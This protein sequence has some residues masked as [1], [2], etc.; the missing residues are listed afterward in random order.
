M[1][2]IISHTE[3]D[4]NSIKKIIASFGER[5]PF[6]SIGSIGK[7]VS[8]RDL[9]AIRIGRANEYVLYVGA[10]HGTERITSV[11]LLKFVEEFCEALKNNTQISGVDAQ[12]AMFGRGL[13]VVPVIN[14]DGCEIALNGPTSCGYFASKISRL[15]SGNYQKWNANMRGVDIN[16]NFDAGWMELHELEQKSGIYGPGATRY[17][18]HRPE[19]EPETVALTGLCR[20]VKIRHVVAFHSQGEVIYWDYGNKHIPRAKKM[21]EIMA[22][23]TGYALEVPTG[24]ASGG[25]FKDWFIEKYGRPG[26]TVEM[27]MGE[28]PLQPELAPQIYEKLREM[29]V[30]SILM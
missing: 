20:S 16:H 21:A 19:S 28:N 11:V 26:F 10:F 30:I 15:S 18:G 17:G 27:G 25:G 5:Y 6:I 8:G 9:P 13:I 12:K 7:S 3:H 22:T 1:K 2:S 29:M 24:L 14:P 23:S 4:Y